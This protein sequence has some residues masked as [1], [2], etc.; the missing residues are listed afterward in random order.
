M[1]LKFYLVLCNRLERMGTDTHN[2]SKNL[3]SGKVHPILFLF[4]LSTKLYL[5]TKKKEAKKKRFITVVMVLNINIYSN[6][7]QP[8]SG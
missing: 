8:I 2:R 1:I 7:S 3:A 6:K 4:D 5:L